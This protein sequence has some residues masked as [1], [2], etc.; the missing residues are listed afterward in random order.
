MQIKLIQRKTLPIIP[1]TM[2]QVKAL[3]QERVQTR[4]IAYHHMAPLVSDQ[5]HSFIT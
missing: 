5:L 4:A 2:I 1:V 3:I